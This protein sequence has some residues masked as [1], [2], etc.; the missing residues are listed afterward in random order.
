MRVVGWLLTALAGSR[1]PHS[2]QASVTHRPHDLKRPIS[3]ASLPLW[4]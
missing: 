4:L 3:D 2:Q 1:F